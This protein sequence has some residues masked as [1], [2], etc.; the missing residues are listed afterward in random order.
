MVTPET[1]AD[2]ISVAC[3]RDT[4]Q[5]KEAVNGLVEI[6]R[7]FIIAVIA[8]RETNIENVDDLCQDFIEAKLIS[9]R[10]FQAWD[11]NPRGHFRDYLRRSILNFCNDAW[12]RKSKVPRELSLHLVD[13]PN[14]FL[15]ERYLGE[16]VYLDEDVVWA[17]TLFA[18]TISMMKSE[19]QQKGQTEIWQL[20]FDNVLSDLFL[21]AENKKGGSLPKDQRSRNLLVSANRKFR[22]LLKS[23][24]V[25]AGAAEHDL[26]A[27]EFQALL[28]RTI[29]DPEL[30][31]FLVSRQFFS[32]EIS[33]VF[34]SGSV[35]PKEV[36]LAVIRFIDSEDQRKWIRL[37]EMDS[38]SE[39]IDHVKISDPAFDK[40]SLVSLTIGDLLFG[41]GEI[42][43]ET[44]HRIRK[45]ARDLASNETE[46]EKSIY[47][48]LYTHLICRL[49]T[50]WNV[51]ATRLNS[52]QLQ[53]NI[54]QCLSLDWL[55]GDSHALLK[56]ALRALSQ[57]E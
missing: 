5:G 39:K 4:S 9:G 36:H 57:E 2:L 8:T 22:R 53:H 19:C 54:N 40:P 33:R 7:P 37:L 17:R 31:S 35:S 52:V 10:V 25:E 55:D 24:L 46:S 6:Y 28:K 16:D 1:N 14:Q 18:K 29:A 26:D 30:V 45:K 48:V 42:S 13:E 20:F 41:D 47:Y 49:L 50:K 32:D 11:S 38:V 12:G 43:V 23:Q 27:A 21:G 56:G 15:S 51:R 44:L 34:L 3:Q